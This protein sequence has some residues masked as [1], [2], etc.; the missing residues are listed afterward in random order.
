MNFLKR[1]QFNRS[2]HTSEQQASLP[3]EVGSAIDA[4][5]SLEEIVPDMD[6][7]ELLASAWGMPYAAPTKADTAP[8]EADEK[9]D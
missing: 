1:F 5:I 2:T 3:L 6:S 4:F 8:T 9:A 7:L